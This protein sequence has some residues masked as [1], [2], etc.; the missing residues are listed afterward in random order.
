MSTISAKNHVTAILRHAF[1]PIA[2]MLLM[3][4]KSQTT[5]F[6]MYI[7]NP[8]ENGL[9]YQPQLVEHSRISEASAVIQP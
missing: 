7:P 6:W 3:V 1:G 4:Q 2:S 5:T 8:V 9:I